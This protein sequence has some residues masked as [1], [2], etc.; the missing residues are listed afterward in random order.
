LYEFDES[1][2]P[3]YKNI[4]IEVL[5]DWPLT[6]AE[7]VSILN[8]EMILARAYYTPPLHR[9]RMAYPHVS[10]NLPVTDQLAERFILP[11]CGHFVSN[12]DIEEIIGVFG[13]MSAN[14]SQIRSRLQQQAM[15]A[16]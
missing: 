7:T 15:Q 1:Q 2:Q 6:R 4:L 11:P 12:K 10:S 5:D 16:Q 14:A 9:K 8:A 13:F 3:G